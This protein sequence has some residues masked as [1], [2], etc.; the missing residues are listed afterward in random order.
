MLGKKR[1]LIDT[2]IIIVSVGIVLLIMSSTPAKATSGGDSPPVSPPS[3]NSGIGGSSQINPSS[4]GSQQSQPPSQSQQD[5]GAIIGDQG[6]SKPKDN[7]QDDNQ[8]VDP[9]GNAQ[10]PDQDA[11]IEDPSDDKL[12]DDLDK[13]TGAEHIGEHESS[14]DEA[15]EKSIKD[16]DKSDLKGMDPSQDLENPSDEIELNEG[17][18]TGNIYDDELLTVPQEDYLGFGDSDNPFETEE[19]NDRE[20]KPIN[21]MKPKNIDKSMSSSFK[22]H[23][24]S[25]K[26]S[27]HISKVIE[28]PLTKFLVGMYTRLD[29]TSDLQGVRKKIYEYI[30]A[31][32]GEHMATLIREFGLSSSSISHH[33]NVLEKNGHILAH[34]DGRYKRLFANHNGYISTVDTNYKDIISVLKNDNSKRIMFYLLAKPQATQNELSQS[35]NLHPSTIHWHVSK[36]QTLKLIHQERDG[37]NVKYSID[38]PCLLLKVLNLTETG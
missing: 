30:K 19:L 10:N 12:K 22:V 13:L 17:D 2:L 37:K 1:V 6:T 36:L 32:P 24:S 23:K 5:D 8:Y 16:F 3:S 31:H 4:G 33:I 7:G 34:S 29:S 28:E 20:L 26:A 21:S 38:D 11:K 18:E 15:D 14:A 27:A 25:I 35:L 9:D